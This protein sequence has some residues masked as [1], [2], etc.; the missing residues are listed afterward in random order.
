MATSPLWNLH[1]FDAILMNSD[2][3]G[4]KTYPRI[5]SEAV[6]NSF[7]IFE[8]ARNCMGGNTCFQVL[9]Q[10]SQKER[11]KERERESHVLYIY[12]K[13]KPFTKKKTHT[14]ITVLPRSLATR[15]VS[16]TLFGINWFWFDSKGSRITNQS[17]LP[18]RRLLALK[19]LSVPD[20]TQIQ[21]LLRLNCHA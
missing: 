16:W 11:E 20:R 7:T 2:V 8:S 3:S 15:L 19:L 13:Q 1:R 6:R 5:A 18:E 17:S 9:N 4:S 12:T 14:D 21:L 10:E